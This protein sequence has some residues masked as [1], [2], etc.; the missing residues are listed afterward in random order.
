MSCAGYFERLRRQ[1]E[2]DSFN[3]QVL[4]DIQQLKDRLAKKLESLMVKGDFHKANEIK[5]ELDY[6]EKTEKSIKKLV[7]TKK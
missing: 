2:Q 4:H 1:A 5:A 7:E 3:N 6:L